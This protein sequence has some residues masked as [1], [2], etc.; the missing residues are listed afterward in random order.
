[1][2]ECQCGR[3]QNVDP[4]LGICGICG[5]RLACNGCHKVFCSDET[6]ED[7]YCHYCAMSWWYDY[8]E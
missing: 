8:V 3:W 5:K 2:V 7:G 4:E 1:M 6:H